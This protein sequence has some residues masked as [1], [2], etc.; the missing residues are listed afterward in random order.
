MP[1]ST[2]TRFPRHPRRP[3]PSR[4]PSRIGPGMILA[5]LALAFAAMLGPGA[6][7]ALPQKAPNSHVLMQLPDGYQPARQYSGFEHAGLGVSFVIMELPATSYA[8]L[9]AG[10]SPEGL[11]ARGIANVQRGQLDRP[12]AHEYLVGAQTSPAGTFA[13]FFLTFRQRGLA[14]LV[15]AN[16]PNAALEKGLVQ[17][18]DI[19]KVLASA[20]VGITRMA[21]DL[22]RL[23]HLGPFREAGV[24]AGTSRLYTLDGKLEPA[25]K[26]AT[27]AL[28]LVEPSLDQEPLADPAK[29]AASLLQALPGYAD[30]EITPAEPV[31]IGGVTGIALHAT[32]RNATDGAQVRL[33]QLL[34][35]GRKG[36]FYRL[37]G[38]AAQGQA[39]TLLPQIERMAASFRMLP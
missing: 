33:Y 15:T 28:F 35:P 32:A 37:L 26:G 5:A 19:E 16:V 4:S 34:V 9:T 24:I 23:D 29:T 20:R 7:V 21:H 39:T 25:H 1:G 22:Y 3:R 11:A 13:K 36:G 10:L 6:A 27:R 2:I 31:E 30:I 38:Q 14:V 8:D 17:A 12:G 18:G